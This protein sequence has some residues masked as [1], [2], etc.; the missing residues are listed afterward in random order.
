MFGVAFNENWIRPK[1]YL[2]ETGI[3]VLKGLKAL[4][5]IPFE[6]NRIRTIV[7]R[8]GFGGGSNS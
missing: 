6:G 7:N 8:P 5:F 4:L 3:N 1:E 2:G